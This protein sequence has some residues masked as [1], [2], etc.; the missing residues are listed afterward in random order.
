LIGAIKEFANT[1]SKTLA[2]NYAKAGLPAAQA[3]VAHRKKDFA[4]VVELLTPARSDLWMMGGS[5]AQ[6]DLFYQM[7]VD[8][9]ARIGN[10]EAVGTLMNEIEQIGVV[11]PVQ[12]SAYQAIAL[13]CG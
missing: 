1:D 4:R 9:T 2:V 6:Q 11:E 8:A 13:R 12:L 7:L 3:A 10:T 5:H